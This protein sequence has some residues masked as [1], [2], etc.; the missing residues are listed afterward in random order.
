MF[1]LIGVPFSDKRWRVYDTSHA[2]PRAE[3][4]QETLAWLDRYFGPVPIE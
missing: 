3:M 1:D 4:A 2:L